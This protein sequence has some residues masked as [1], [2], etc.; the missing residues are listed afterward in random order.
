MP[1]LNDILN[2]KISDQDNV[3]LEVSLTD[4]FGGEVPDSS[5]FRQEVGQ[6]I[7]DKIRSRTEHHE[8]LNNAKQ[9]YSESYADSTAFKAYGKSKS[10][11]N[12]TQTGDMLGLMDI[13]SESSDKIVIGWN[14]SLQSN[15][16]H[17]HITGNVGAKRNFFGLPADD[18]KSIAGKFES[19]VQSVQSDSSPTRI[20]DLTRSFINGES[21]N[22]KSLGASTVGRLISIFLGEEET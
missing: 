19:E 6:A 17:G 18:L 16:A 5:T 15:K 22:S 11:V 2:Q 20:S 10:D 7:I 4:M 14:D 21:V 8:Y 12:L 1:K 13:I 9:K 3:T